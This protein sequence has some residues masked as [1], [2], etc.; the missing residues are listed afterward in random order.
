MDLSVK[1]ETMIEKH[2][3]WFDK[4][5]S[6]AYSRMSSSDF[7]SKILGFIH[8]SV[9]FYLYFNYIFLIFALPGMLCSFVF[10]VDGENGYF[11]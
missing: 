4:N 9:I 6:K 10:E 11:F 8:G 2:L 7:V 5:F 1:N 3:K